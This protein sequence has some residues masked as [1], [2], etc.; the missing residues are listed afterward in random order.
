MRNKAA[1][2]GYHYNPVMMISMNGM[3]ANPDPLSQEAVGHGGRDRDLLRLVERLQHASG[4][5]DLSDCAKMT[6]RDGLDYCWRP[7][8][9]ERVLRS[10]MALLRQFGFSFC[11]DMEAITVTSICIIECPWPSWFQLPQVAQPPWLSRAMVVESSS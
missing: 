3:P 8:K 9:G 2:V 11:G 6:L 7:W 5:A 1:S 4:T 10:R